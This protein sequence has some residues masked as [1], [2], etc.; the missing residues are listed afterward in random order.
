ME[1]ADALSA[2]H[3]QR[4]VTANIKPENILLVAG[5]P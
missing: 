3:A 5:T 2:A 1:V 4:I